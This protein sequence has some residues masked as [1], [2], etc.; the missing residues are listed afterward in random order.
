[1]VSTATVIEV[2]DERPSSA[3]NEAVGGGDSPLPWVSVMVDGAL[4]AQSYPSAACHVLPANWASQAVN[5]GDLTQLPVSAPSPAYPLR[6]LEERYLANRPY[7]KL[8]DTTLVYLNP[9]IR[10]PPVPASSGAPHRP[11]QPSPQELASMALERLLYGKNENDAP[12]KRVAFAVTGISGAGKTMAL[13]FALEAILAKLSPTGQQGGDIRD[14]GS[15]RRLARAAPALELFGNAS[16]RHNANSSRF[17][18]QV[19][20]FIVDG[21]DVDRHRQQVATLEG[22]RLT[23]SLLEV[24]RVVERAT[25]EGPFHVIRMLFTSLPP[26]EKRRLDLWDPAMFRLAHQHEGTLPPLPWTFD[27]LQQSLRAVGI[28]KADET[29]MW[30]VLAAIMHLGNTEFD[31]SDDFAP[32]SVRKLDCVNKVAGLLGVGVDT[33]A[34]TLTSVQLGPVRRQ[35]HREAATRVRDT[36]CRDL[37]VFCSISSSP[38]ATRRL[39]LQL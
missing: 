31:A 24:S 17:V 14:H 19:S 4:E 36:M 23:A 34:E 32:V 7:T 22:M 13:S 20:L 5:C 6:S 2:L 37:T 28:S 29:C 27:D 30:E 12:Y 35:L 15:I 10:L 33:L 3:S 25:G 1:M 26:A 21:E 9:F 11:P 38:D 16:T 18:K 39:R 8:G